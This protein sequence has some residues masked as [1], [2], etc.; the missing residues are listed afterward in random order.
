[1]PHSREGVGNTVHVR[2]SVGGE[3]YHRRDL[4]KADLQGVC[5]ANFHA[6]VQMCQLIQLR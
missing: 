4:E 1:M 5:R 6:V 2:V 3:S